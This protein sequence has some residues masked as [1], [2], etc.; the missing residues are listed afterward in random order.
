MNLQK[1]YENLNELL[2]NDL[3]NNESKFS[4][5]ELHDIRTV[6]VEMQIGK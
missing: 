2:E 5:R 4:L 3:N 1:V 6:L